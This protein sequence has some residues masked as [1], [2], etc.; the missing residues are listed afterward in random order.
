M[1][2]SLSFNGDFEFDCSESKGAITL[3]N[4]LDVLNKFP[5]GLTDENHLDIYVVSGGGSVE[6][7]TAIVAALQVWSMRPSNTL[8]IHYCAQCSSAVTKLFALTNAYHAVYPDAYSVLHAPSNISS[9]NGQGGVDDVWFKMEHCDWNQFRSRVEVT[10][11][12][13]QDRPWPVTEERTIYAS[14]IATLIESY[15]PSENVVTRVNSENDKWNLASPYTQ[16]ST[17]Y[18]L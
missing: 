18:D 5:S 12:F 17:P 9:K 8:V 7:A 15:M 10:L 6:T 3:A 16:F 1:Q 11:G 4:V 13:N 2:Y 14:E